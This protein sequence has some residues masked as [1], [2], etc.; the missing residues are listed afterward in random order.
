MSSFAS[1]YIKYVNHLEQINDAA[2]N[3]PKKM[4]EEVEYS[5]HEHL[6]TIANDIVKHKNNIRICLLAGPSSSGKTTTANLLC[7]YLKE[8]GKNA[9]IVSLDD[10][11]KNQ[12]D[13]PTRADGTKDFETVYSLSVEKVTECIKN[14]VS[15]KPFIVPEFSF[16]LGK[17]IS[18]K[19]YILGENDIVI[20]EG[21]H[22]LNPIFTNEIG[23]N[24]LLKLYVSIKQPIKDANGEVLTAEEARL[25]RRMVRDIKFRDCGTEETL[26]MWQDVMDGEDKY[27][28]PYRLSADYTVNS[29][30]IY[31]P[32]VLRSIAIPMIRQVAEYS[33]YY[34]KAR[35]IEAKLMRFEKIDKSLVPQNSVLREFIGN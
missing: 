23:E 29:I 12:N 15:L 16:P 25:V 31:E 24:Q 4:I 6:Q 22:A 5:Y 11:Y 34:R 21:L 3:N 17:S 10:F 30:H 18:E 33:P 9:F 14:I 19:E 20:M 28:R 32:C 35:A 27:I 26:S 7:K 2:I 13:A 8:L 1:G